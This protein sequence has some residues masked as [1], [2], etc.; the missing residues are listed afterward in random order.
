MRKPK[1]RAWSIAAALAAFAAVA[2]AVDFQVNIG[3]PPPPPTM[4]FER[5]PEV[6]L[7]PRTHVYYVPKVVDY[8]VYRVGSYWYANRD[9]YW[10]RARSYRG[11]F[12]FV[13]HRYVP[14]QVFVVPVEYRRHPGHPHGGPPGQMKKMYDGHGHGK[15][16]H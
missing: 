14:Q 3:V 7:V 10:Y 1:V 5:E 15:H 11:P 13:E 9:G 2:G 6:V 8:D 4:V 16:E 12:A